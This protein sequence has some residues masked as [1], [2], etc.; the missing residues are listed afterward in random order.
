MGRDAGRDPFMQ[1]AIDEA[2]A[3]L[4]DEDIGA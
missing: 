3:G 2:R 4:W 1:A